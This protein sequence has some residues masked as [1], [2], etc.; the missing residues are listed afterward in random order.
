MGESYS[1]D[2]RERE[3]QAIEEGMSK[4]RAHYNPGVLGQSIAV[5]KAQGFL[6]IETLQGVSGH[7]EFDIF[8]NELYN[9]K[10]LGQCL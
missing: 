10:V 5:L 6:G 9:E 1:T 4:T 3:S 7:R 8:L 2:S